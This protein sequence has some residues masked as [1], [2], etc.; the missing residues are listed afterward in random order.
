[1]QK[2]FQVAAKLRRA[3]IVFSAAI[4]GACALPDPQTVSDDSLC[5]RYGNNIRA[6]DP[7]RAAAISTE[8]ERRGL[9]IADE[10]V[11]H[12][13]R[14]IVRVGMTT[15]AMRAAWGHSTVDNRTTTGRAVRIQHVWRGFTG[16]YV[17]TRSSFVYSENGIVVAVQN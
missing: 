4:L 7:Q 16:Q 12:I 8:M 5:V 13:Q 11:T 6:N 9:R 14:Q 15:C 1:M 17:R 3:L 10:D 2:R